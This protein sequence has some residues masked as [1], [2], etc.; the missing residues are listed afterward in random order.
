MLALQDPAT[1]QRRHRLDKTTLHLRHTYRVIRVPRGLS[2]RRGRWSVRSRV[3]SKARLRT[4]TASR[5]DRVSGRL[6]ARVITAMSSSVD[7]RAFSS[8]RMNVVIRMDIR[9]A[10]GGHTQSKQT[11]CAAGDGRALVCGACLCWDFHRAGPPEYLCPAPG[12]ACGVPLTGRALPGGDPPRSA[13]W[14]GCAPVWR[15]RVGRC[16]PRSHRSAQRCLIWRPAP[17]QLS[18]CGRAAL[19]VA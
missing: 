9:A 3:A 5:P 6:R 12:W 10:Y 13:G 19:A 8:S 18:G 2:L 1:V 14:R 17:N 4:T 11:Y 16:Q 15:C 7:E